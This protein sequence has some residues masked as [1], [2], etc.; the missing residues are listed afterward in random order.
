MELKEHDYSFDPLHGHPDKRTNVKGCSYFFL[1]N[2]FI[3]TA[4]QYNKSDEPLTPLG[5]LI[6]DPTQFGHK[7]D[8]FSF[9]EQSGLER[10]MIGI[11][12]GGTLFKPTA[13]NLSMKWEPQ[14]VIPTV[15]AN[16]PAGACAVHEHFY[17]P[18][19]RTPA[20]L[21]KI[22]IRNSS[23]EPIAGNLLIDRN[24]SDRKTA[25]QTQ[26]PFEIPV[27][28]CSDFFFEY[29]ITDRQNNKISV[30]LL[31]KEPSSSD[32]RAFWSAIT[33][34]QFE[35]ARLNHLFNS[36]RDQLTT[37]IAA[38]GQMDASTWQYNLE[39]VRDASFVA[40][41]CAMAGYFDTARAMLT[42]LVTDFV[43]NDGSTVDSGRVRPL[44][45][46]ELDQNGVLLQA[47]WTYRMWTGDTHFIAAHWDK[48]KLLAEF[49][50]QDIYWDAKTRLLK[51]CRELWER[52]RAFGVTSGYELAYQVF[53]VIG[54]SHAAAMARE[55]D[56]P[57]L[58][59][60]WQKASDEIR[61]AML[62][63]PTFAMVS[64]GHFIKRRKESGE[65]HRYFEPPDKS[66]LHDGV[67][68]K[69]LDANAV[70]PD[71]AATFAIFNDVV[72]PRGPIATNTLAQL[73]LL[74]N[75]TWDHGGYAR[76][77]VTSEADIAGPWPLATAMM[78]RAYLENEN[79]DKVRRALDWLF[80][81][82]ADTGSYLEIEHYGFR[83]SPPMPPLGVITWSWSE[84]VT[85][86]IHHLLGIRPLK[87]KIIIRPRLLSLAHSVKARVRIRDH[88]LTLHLHKQA[89]AK[90]PLAIINRDTKTDFTGQLTL[91]YMAADYFVEISI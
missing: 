6:M 89:D 88:Y 54:L 53:P 70:D 46:V 15:A 38:N 11:E 22:S 23:G 52:H 13:K 9:D 65:I 74:W 32:A 75:Q 59:E 37:A 83:P 66:I 36:A 87:D 57:Q 35:D 3:Q 42:R 84:L 24:I 17:C 51:N 44:E 10:T 41:A 48:I 25:I 2:G 71:T 86:F 78:A 67:P 34:I 43:D 58:A 49:P 16:W 55:M 4:V 69:E 81:I 28:E 90:K 12:I 20:L 27:G 91:P 85:F 26:F 73:E 60:R 80:E 18:N 82:S 19:R 50:L 76:Y 8:A 68:L 1:G 79:S 61:Q 29:V 30:E 64:D 63:H 14:S 5:L 62:F 40:E 72:D 45:E 31:A 47:I 21:R 56:D 7:S 33:T 77:N 39:W